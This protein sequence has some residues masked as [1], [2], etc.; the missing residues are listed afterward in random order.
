MEQV[1]F[2]PCEVAQMIG[3]DVQTIYKMIK[4]GRLPAANISRTFG[5]GSSYRI[6]QHA[7]DA[8]MAPIETNDHKG[9]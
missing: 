3:V 8:L 6:A 2:S 1:Y 7:I 9:D 5:T 4:D